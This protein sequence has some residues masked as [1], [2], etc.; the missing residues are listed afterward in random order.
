[1]ISP[2]R[3]EWFVALRYLRAKRKGAVL[4]VV[5]WVSML[6]VAT[7]VMSL[8]V[9]LAVNT[10]FKQ[11]LQDRL[12]GVTAHINLTRA[13]RE[14]ISDYRVLQEKLKR[15]PHVVAVAPAVYDT[16]LLSGRARSKGVVLK[17]I[18]V[19]SEARVGDLLGSIKQGSARELTNPT[20][21]VEPLLVGKELASELGLFP[22]DF[23][24]ITSPQGRLTPLGLVPRYQ[25]FRIVGIFESGFYDYDS[26][27]VFTS[28]A[29]AQRL[30]GLGDLVSVLEFKIDDIYKA[31]A[32]GKAIEQ[33][34]GPGFATSNWMELNRS[35]FRALRLEKLV[36]AIFIG[37][38]VFVAGLNILIALTM[39]VMEKK[40]EIAVLMSMGARVEQIRRI[41][42]YQGLVIG[43]LG[44]VLGLAAGYGLAWLGDT[45]RLIRLDREVYA[46]AYVPFRAKIADAVWI[47]ALALGTSWL[48]TIYPATSAARILPVEVLR[49]E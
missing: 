6:G 26:A 47:V 27:W 36:T 45:Y 25:R 32:V 20:P 15:V 48:A 17:G 34:A 13:K 46:I 49:Y 28:L 33:A 41:F 31:E 43:L 2:Q 24:T 38:I 39:T 18:D 19:E 35:L 16:V 4:S 23:V 30:T 22:G 44:T 8:V 3:F 40:R 7:G 21:D 37:L 14:G 42:L 9:A 1:M 10:G 12:L 5:T 11:V 29:A